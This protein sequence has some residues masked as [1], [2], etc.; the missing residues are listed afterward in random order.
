MA[1]RRSLRAMGVRGYRVHSDNLPGKPDLS[2]ARWHLAVFVDGC[3]W[4]ACEKCYVAPSSNTEYWGPKIARNVE[5]DRN[6][7]AELGCSGWR[8]VRIWEHEIEGD[9]V[10][11]ARRV[12]AALKDLGWPEG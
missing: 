8:V 3:F 10:G 11:A 9:P 6:V 12:V 5:R 2:F 1:L 4:H 7:D